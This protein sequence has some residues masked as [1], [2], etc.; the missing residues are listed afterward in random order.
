M[1][2]QRSAISD[3]LESRPLGEPNT[4][5]GKKREPGGFF[6]GPRRAPPRTAWFRPR[7][8]KGARTGC[9]RLI[10]EAGCLVRSAPGPG[11]ADAGGGPEKDEGP[12]GTAPRRT[13]AQGLC[14]LGFP[15]ERDA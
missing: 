9:P 2:D 14:A 11:T 15:A 12:G 10:F 5:G 8:P 7:A 1:S 6:L 13:G 3:Q 4:E